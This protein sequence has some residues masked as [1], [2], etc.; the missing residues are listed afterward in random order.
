ME[1]FQGKFMRKMETHNVMPVGVDF[2]TDA[3]N[4][5]SGQMQL[6]EILKFRLQAEAVFK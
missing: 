4:R 2:T 3:R 6:I 1:T 5:G